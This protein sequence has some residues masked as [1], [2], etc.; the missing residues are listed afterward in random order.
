MLTE[1]SAQGWYGGPQRSSGSEHKDQIRLT[2]SK[3]VHGAGG[4][5]KVDP[6]YETAT[7][8]ADMKNE[9]TVLQ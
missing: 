6:E 7:K 1:G 2:W 9:E 3:P 4:P 8:S 5:Q